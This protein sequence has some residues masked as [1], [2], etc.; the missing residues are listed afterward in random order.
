MLWVS[1]QRWSLLELS[2][3]LVL[4]L[5]Q[6]AN[7]NFSSGYRS[8]GY[9]LFRAKACLKQQDLYLGFPENYDSN[10]KPQN[11]FPA[12]IQ[13]FLAQAD[14]TLKAG[15][16]S[17]SLNLLNLFLNTDPTCYSVFPVCWTHTPSIKQA[18]ISQTES[19]E[20]SPDCL[21]NMTQT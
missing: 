17:R 16:C 13:S 15:K 9:D 2:D 4:G 1:A 18:V 3:T 21:E 5:H 11:G 20:I 19:P 7:P 6:E 8:M 10:T 12:C 14:S